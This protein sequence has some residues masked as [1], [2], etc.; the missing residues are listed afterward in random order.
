MDQF[1][2]VYGRE[3]HALF[4]DCRSLEWS[5]IPVAGAR[6][7]ICNTKTKHDLADSEYNKRRAECE[8]AA[9]FLGHS[10]LRDVSITEFDS[11]SAE[12]PEIPRKRARHV[13]TENARVLGAVQALKD[14]DLP[15]F[16]ALMNASHES[17]RDDYQVSSSE[18]DIMV[19]LAR[20]Q[21]GVLGAR[22]TGGG[23]GGCTINL[24]EQNAGDDFAEKMSEAYK[25]ETGIVPESYMFAISAGVSEL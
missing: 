5:A 6:F 7:V 8:E 16:G 3:D 19:S 1:A 25:R 14:N 4:L 24:L 13:I 12:M 2:S 18:L 21:E 17:L 10:S 11:R 20:K 23:F 9:S 15:H 22:M